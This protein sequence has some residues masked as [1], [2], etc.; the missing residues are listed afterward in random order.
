MED[1]EDVKEL[2][3]GIG[4]IKAIVP[5]I[6]SKG[7]HFDVLLGMSYLKANKEIIDVVNGNIRKQGDQITYK[8]WPELASIYHRMY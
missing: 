8:A 5:A 7:L 4:N 6:V 3:A 1:Q 2:K